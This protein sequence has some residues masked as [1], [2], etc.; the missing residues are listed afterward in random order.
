MALIP[1]LVRDPMLYK[2]HEFMDPMLHWNGWI[3]KCQVALVITNPISIQ[4]RLFMN[5]NYPN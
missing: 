2:I 4:V 3:T 5:K 1:K